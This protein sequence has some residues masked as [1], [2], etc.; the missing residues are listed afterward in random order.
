MIS[1]SYQQAIAMTDFAMTIN[2][3]GK[4]LNPSQARSSWMLL[5][6]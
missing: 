2:M 1:V 3:Q 5:C 6:K 4:K